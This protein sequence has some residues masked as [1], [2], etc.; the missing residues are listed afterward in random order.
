MSLTEKQMTDAL[1][2]QSALWEELADY[3]RGIWEA[4]AKAF[5]QFRLDPTFIHDVGLE[6]LLPIHAGI[7]TNV[8]PSHA[9]PHGA[10]GM[11]IYEDDKDS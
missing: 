2:F 6:R 4:L 8:L 10:S 3:L 9:N 5:E 11:L 1:D 7:A